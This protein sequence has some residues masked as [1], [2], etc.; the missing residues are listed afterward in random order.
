[1]LKI[2][3]FDT[4]FRSTET[5]IRAAGEQ[6]VIIMYLL[7]IP[8]H[9]KLQWRI[10]VCK[11]SLWDWSFR[12]QFVPNAPI[13]SPDAPNW[14]RMGAIGDEWGRMGAFPN[15]MGA[16][17]FRLQTAFQVK[18]EK[19]SASSDPSGHKISFSNGNSLFSV[20]YLWLWV[21]ANFTPKCGKEA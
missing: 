1:M 11:K 16:A 13:V 12:S 18:N 10:Q 7:P 14:G 21:S 20:L 5:F 4:L 17:I 9:Q 15:V 2:I 3:K 6:V 19:R 8:L